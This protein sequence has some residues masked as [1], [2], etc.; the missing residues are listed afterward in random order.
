MAAGNVKTAFSLP[1][2]VE[3]RL[4]QEFNVIATTAAT[5]RKYRPTTTKY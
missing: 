3:R 5:A 2:G 1:S 4:C